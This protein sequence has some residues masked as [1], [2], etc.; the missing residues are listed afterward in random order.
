MENTAE[1]LRQV[2]IF[3]EL[4]GRDLKRLAREMHHRSFK[5]GEDIV[6]QGESGLGFFIITSG[7]ATVRLENDEIG[8]LGPGEWFGEMSIVDGGARA[9]TV[10][11][12]EDLECEAMTAWHFKPFVAEHPDFAWALI[13]TLVKRLRGSHAR[14]MEAAH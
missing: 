5:A 2:P 11:A 4:S 9:A 10:H 13:Q 3:S 6:L 7:R 12:E 14:A 8:S 1:A